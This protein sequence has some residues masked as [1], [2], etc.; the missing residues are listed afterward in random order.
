MTEMNSPLVADRTPEV[1]VAPELVTH[2]RLEDLTRG[3]QGPFPDIGPT[4]SSLG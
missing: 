4:G 1:W 2:G 3:Q